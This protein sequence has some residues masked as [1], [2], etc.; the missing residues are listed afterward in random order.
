MV[1][2]STLF[3]PK[4]GDV[5]VYGIRSST[6]MKNNNNLLGILFYSKVRMVYPTYLNVSNN[7]VLPIERKQVWNHMFVY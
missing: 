3:F 5:V 2:P 7:K 1:Q 4:K 6:E